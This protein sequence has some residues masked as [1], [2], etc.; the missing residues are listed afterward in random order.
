MVNMEI[1]QGVVQRLP[2]LKMERMDFEIKSFDCIFGTGD[3]CHN[4]P[5]PECTYGSCAEHCRCGKL[6]KHAREQYASKTEKRKK[7]Y[8]DFEPKHVQH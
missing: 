5:S 6:R 1:L 2:F 7:E 8:P 4:P 3:M